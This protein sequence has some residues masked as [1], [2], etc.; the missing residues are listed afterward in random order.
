MD[1]GLASDFLTRLNDC[2]KY[3]RLTAHHVP[4]ESNF[5]K[6]TKSFTKKAAYAT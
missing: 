6:L 4:T 3:S 2:V 5:P 1:R